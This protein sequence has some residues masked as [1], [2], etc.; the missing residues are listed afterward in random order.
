VIFSTLF[1]SNFKLDFYWNFYI[2]QQRLFLENQTKAVWWS[3]AV[4]Y[5]SNTV[6]TVYSY[7]AYQWPF[8]I[9]YGILFALT[10]ANKY[11]T[12]V[13]TGTRL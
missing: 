6:T 7:N 12:H 3:T 10:V 2:A 4:Y 13:H 8:S 11:A 9:L 5:S 1:Q